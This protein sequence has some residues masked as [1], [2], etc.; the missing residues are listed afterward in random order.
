M[1]WTKPCAPFKS[2]LVV[3]EF[4]NQIEIIIRDLGTAIHHLVAGIIVV[5]FVTLCALFC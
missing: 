5:R 4:C 3:A 1:S 2:P